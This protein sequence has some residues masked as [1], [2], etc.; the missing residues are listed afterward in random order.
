[1]KLLQEVH[2]ST[3]GSERARAV[4]NRDRWTGIEAVPLTHRLQRALRF[5][6]RRLSLI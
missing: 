5:E 3:A 4:F 2:R 6:R 1:M